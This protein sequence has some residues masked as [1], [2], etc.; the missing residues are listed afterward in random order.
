MDFL[1]RYRSINALFDHKELE[2]LSIYFAKPE[3]LND[4][5]EKHM[6]VVWQG[7]KIAFQGLFKHY[8]YTL[9][10]LYVKARITEPQKHLDVDAIPVFL[11]IKILDAPEMKDLFKFIYYEFF[12]SIYINKFPEQ[13]ALSNKKFTSDEILWVFK[14]I[15]LYA[16]LV[17]NTVM[18]Y[19]VF[20]KDIL[21]DKSYAEVYS[22]VKNWDGYY[23]VLKIL[24]DP[25]NSPEDIY[26]N[27]VNFCAQ[28]QIN[29]LYLSNVLHGDKDSYNINVLSFDF[30]DLYMK[31]IKKILYEDFGV[32][33]FSKTFRNEPMW[34]HYADKENGVCLKYKVKNNNGQNYLNLYSV[35][36]TI[37]DSEREHTEKSF[38]DVPIFKVDYSINY[39]E[40]DFFTS[41]GVLPMPI[42]EGFWLCNYDKTEFSSCLKNYKPI[43][44]WAINYHMNAAK[45]ICT[46]NINWNYEQEYRIFQRDVLYRILENKENRIATYS[47][48]DLDAIIFGRNVK[49]EDKRKII[50]IVFEHCKK[51][52]HE[53][54][55]YDLYFSTIT[56]QLEYRHCIESIVLNPAKGM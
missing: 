37:I 10:H 13:M 19:K 49:F 42:I 21:Q 29:S 41:L 24:T 56:G 33:C 15:N 40:I 52:S 2:N 55:F 5:M 8:L 17:I 43:E 39:P 51:Q 47:I 11:D 36:N 28:Q 27:M 18:Q 3:E 35:S 22:A 4:Q 44:Q 48:K 23:N 9:T 16:Y 53:V 50:N 45:Y 12:N 30:P 7:D 1:Y 34:S 31:H 26:K 20:N 14:S 6:N 46:K 38:H 32:I 54:K 25:D